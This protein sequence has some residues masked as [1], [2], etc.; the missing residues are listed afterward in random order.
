MGYEQ[1]HPMFGSG[2][3]GPRGR[4]VKA[5][6]LNVGDF[7]KTHNERI[8]NI[9]TDATQIYVT[10]QQAGTIQLDRDDILEIA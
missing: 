7:S 5:T 8:T 1:V 9:R 10:L 6:Q 4:E 2:E 3:A